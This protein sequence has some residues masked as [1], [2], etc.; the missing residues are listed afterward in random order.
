MITELPDPLQ[1]PTSEGEHLD[2]A[3]REVVEVLP[4]VPDIDILADQ[5]LGPAAEQPFGVL[6]DTAVVGTLEVVGVGG[7]RRVQADDEYRQIQ[8]VHCRERW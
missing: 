5:T 3:E 7:V 1:T 6:Q 2:L 4:V 8:V